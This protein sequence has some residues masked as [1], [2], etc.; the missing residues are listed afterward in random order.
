M[1][2]RISPTPLWSSR[3]ASTRRGV[4]E[5][6]DLLEIPFLL[7]GTGALPGRAETDNA[8][9]FQHGGLPLIVANPEGKAVYGVT[10]R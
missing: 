5:L 8:A 7:D 2:R 4:T 10:D 9:G 1:G 3:R 6:L